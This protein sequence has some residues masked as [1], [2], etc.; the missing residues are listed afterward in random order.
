[1]ESIAP[2]TTASASVSRRAVIQTAPWGAAAVTVAVAAPAIAASSA[3]EGPADL[4]IQLLEP[5]VDPQTWA[6]I[7]D[8]PVYAFKSNTVRFRASAPAGMVLTNNGPGTAVNPTGTLDAVMWNYDYDARSSSVNYTL[9]S[10]SAP[11][12]TFSP[13]GRAARSWTWT[14]AGSLLPGQSVT[15]PLRYEVGSAL[16]SIITAA[17][18]QYRYNLFMS[19]TV[20]DSISGDANDTSEKVAYFPGTHNVEDEY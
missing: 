18:S 11:E 4:S 1:M 15:I 12:V 7:Q 8:Q 13:Q 2:T 17:F 19:A 9:V 10:S 16:G 3:P 20:V 6:Y 5:S 14:Y